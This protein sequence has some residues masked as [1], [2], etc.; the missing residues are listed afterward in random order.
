MAVQNEG[1][2]NNNPFILSGISYVRNGITLSQDAGRSAVLAIRTLMAKVATTVPTTG[3]GV[4]TGNGTCTAVAAIAGGSPIAGAWLLTSTLAVA[5]GSIWSLTDP[6]GN[7]VATQLE[8]NAGA[9]LATIFKAGGMTF[10]I[11]DAATDF[12][13]GYVFTITVTADGNWVP[14]EV[15]GVGG[16]EVPA[17]IL[18]VDSVTAAALVAADVTD[19]TMLIG[20]CMTVAS[21]QV[22]FDDGSSTLATVLLNGDTVADALAKI[23]IFTELT[24]DIASYET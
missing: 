16:Q 11:T 1:D 21:D 12:D 17:G 13:L 5:N 9:G 19:Q 3:V 22:I 8:M 10:T 2:L 7:V 20:G 14:W 15:D 4:G 18:M 23:G 6:L 24:V